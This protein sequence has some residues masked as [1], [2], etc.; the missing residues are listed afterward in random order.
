MDNT[1]PPNP[2]EGA[3]KSREEIALKDIKVEHV[4]ILHKVRITYKTDQG[5]ANAISEAISVAKKST[6][7]YG[8]DD[9]FTM[10][11]EKSE[12]VIPIVKR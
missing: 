6:K 10:E 11:I 5:R 4:N 9:A 1:Q 7:R 3:F 12:H 2:L 8:G